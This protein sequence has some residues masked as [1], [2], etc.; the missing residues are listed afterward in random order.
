[1]KALLTVIFTCSLIT[2]FAQKKPSPLAYKDSDSPSARKLFQ[3]A[4][5]QGRVGKYQK[6]KQLYLRALAEDED[7]VEAID[8]LGDI[9]QQVGDLDSAEFYYQQSLKLKPEGVIAGSNLAAV[10]QKQGLQDSAIA[11]YHR[12]ISIYPEYPGAYH[13]LAAIYLN[14]KDYDNGIKA[15]EAALKLYLNAGRPL[16]AA[17][18]RMLAGQGYMH[19]ENYKKAIRYFKASKKHFVAKSYFHYYIGYSY[20]KMGKLAEAQ[21]YLDRSEKM[22]QQLP[23]QVKERLDM[24]KR[25]Y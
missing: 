21:E 3:S 16:L 7:Y 18:A 23:T 10:Y 24:M 4:S 6:A 22:G 17:D 12:L 9:Y 20:M 11:Q 5:D 13:G 19:L 1:M 14:E 8:H 2:S 25:M 15:A